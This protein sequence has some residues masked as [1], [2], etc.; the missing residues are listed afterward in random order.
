MVLTLCWDLYAVLQSFLGLL[1]RMNNLHAA[2]HRT[3]QH[4]L[5]ADSN[6][7]EYDEAVLTLN[8]YRNC[9]TKHS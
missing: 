5:A 3:E 6:I 1:A 9:L 8:S 4:V 7:I 2:M